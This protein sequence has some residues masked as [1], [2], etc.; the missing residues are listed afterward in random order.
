MTEATETRVLICAVAV[1]YGKRSP[2]VLTAPMM[3]I[4][5]AG[6]TC[7]GAMGR[8]VRATQEVWAVWMATGK[9]IWRRVPILPGRCPYAIIE[10]RG[11]PQ[12]GTID[13]GWLS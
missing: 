9:T 3:S 8:V 7:I 10:G 1:A 12:T 11:G 5:P 2:D 6:L 13:V 4:S